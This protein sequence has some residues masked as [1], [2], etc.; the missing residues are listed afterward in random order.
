MPQLSDT[1]LII[2]SN[3]A[4][5]PVSISIEVGPQIGAE[6]GPLYDASLPLSA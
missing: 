2:L 6:K 1:Q 4:Q 3:A 5:H